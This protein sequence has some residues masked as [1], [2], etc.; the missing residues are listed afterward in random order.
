MSLGIYSNNFLFEYNNKAKEFECFNCKLVSP[1]NYFLECKHCICQRCV[2]VYKKCPIDNFKIILNEKHPTAFHFTIIDELLNHFIMKCIFDECDY[3][4][5]YKDFIKK[6]FHECKYRKERELLNEYYKKDKNNKKEK[7]KKNK[8]IVNKNNYHKN[9]FQNEIIDD[10]NEKNEKEYNLDKNE[11]YIILDGS[12]EED[13]N[14][15]EPYS[16]N[17]IENEKFIELENYIQEKIEKSFNGNNKDGKG[18][19]ENFYEINGFCDYNSDGETV[20]IGKKRKRRKKD[21]E[22]FLNLPSSL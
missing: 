17:N 15:I 12:S 3:V 19:K 4:G 22:I 5:K 9:H 21:K 7:N 6:H 16:Q 8:K 14:E 20:E 2:K 1:N 18:K 13:N 10:K 11:K